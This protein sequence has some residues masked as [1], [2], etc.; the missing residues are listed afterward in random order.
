MGEPEGGSM[1]GRRLGTTVGSLVGDPVG[2][3]TGTRVGLRVWPGTVGAGLG[4]RVGATEDGC[5]EGR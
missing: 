1:T 5:S 3:C 2:K 4:L